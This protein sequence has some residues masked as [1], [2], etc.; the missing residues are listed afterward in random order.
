MTPKDYINA[1]VA[2]MGRIDRVYWVACGGSMVDLYPAHFLI[3]TESIVI[4]S[5]IYTARE[6]CLMPPARLDEN[7]LVITCSHSG[8]TPENYEACQL[9]VSRGAYVLAQT[10]KANSLIDSGEWPCWVYEWTDETPQVEKPACYSLMLAAEAIR[11]R[12][13]LPLYDALVADIAK[14]DSVI[15][16]AKAKCDAELSDRFATLCKE[17]AFLYILGSGPTFCQTYGFAICSLQEMQWQDCCY[18]HSG[19]YF[20][21]PFECTE[22]DVFYFLQMGSGANRPMDERALSF[23]T[24]HTDTLMV[25]DALEYGMDVVD[26]AV[27]PYLDPVLFYEMNVTL[28]VARGKAFGHDPDHRRY[29]G[30]VQ[31]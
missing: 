5:A 22:D 13:A 25:L 6:F 18:I 4:E 20:H 31:Y 10:N 26:E 21:G 24:T 17:H 7:S 30:K 28:R 3:N 19:E 2:K 9:A 12:G 11:T 27:R 1:A 14:M 23:L 8:G 29:M 15:A 16:A